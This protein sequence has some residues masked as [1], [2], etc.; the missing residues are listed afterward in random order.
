[1]S[2]TLTYCRNCYKPIVNAESNFCC[3]DC[4]EQYEANCT[5]QDAEC[6]CDRCGSNEHETHVY[7]VG[8]KTMELCDSCYAKYM[9]AISSATS[10][11]TGMKNF[12]IA[13][14]HILMGLQDM[15]FVADE[16]NF[17]DT[18]KRFARAY[19]EIFQDAR[20]LTSKLSRFFQL[21]FRQ[22]VRKHGCC[23]GHCLLFRMSAPLA[24]GGVSRLRR[25]H[26]RQGRK[27]AGDFQACASGKRAS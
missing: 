11:F 8:D 24:S 13:A 12:E 9:E 18:P 15:G 6:R 3:D 17:K 1:M 23:K 21:R 2:N 16:D 20:T 26:P 14:K 5:K 10:E 22:W 7:S 27:R 25:I 4:K 19:S